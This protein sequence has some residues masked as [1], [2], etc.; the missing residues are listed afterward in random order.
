MQASACARQGLRAARHL[1][2]LRGRPPRARG[3]AA[4][5]CLILVLVGASAARRPAPA[6]Q[7]AC[8]SAG[9]GRPPGKVPWGEEASIAARGPPLGAH[10]CRRHSAARGVPG[11][12][13]AAHAVQS[14]RWLGWRAAA[15]KISSRVNPDVKTLYKAKLSATAHN[16]G[17]SGSAC[18]AGRGK[19]ATRPFGVVGYHVRLTRERS[20]VRSW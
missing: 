8:S 17:R 11:R 5:R 4:G 10:V 19:G 7:P 15:A 6:A 2:G 16:V 20:P 14:S 1:Q 12:C 3:P 18:S 9:M 13:G